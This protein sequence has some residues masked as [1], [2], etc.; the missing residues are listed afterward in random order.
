M[1]DNISCSTHCAPNCISRGHPPGADGNDDQPLRRNAGRTYPVADPVDLHLN[2]QTIAVRHAWK[3][4]AEMGEVA[5]G[6]G[7]GRLEAGSLPVPRMAK[8][9]V[10]PSAAAAKAE[11]SLEAVKATI[12]EAAAEGR[13]PDV[14]KI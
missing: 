13:D 8:A 7:N 2:W 11:P 6:A 4:A 5:E 9:G 1:G 12:G 3:K 10:V 14:V